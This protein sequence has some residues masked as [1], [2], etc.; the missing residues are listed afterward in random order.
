MPTKTF[1]EYNSWGGVP[2]IG[3]Q[4][5]HVWI[6][7]FCKIAS[8]TDNYCMRNCVAK[9]R[10]IVFIWAYTCH[11]R[12]VEKKKVRHVLPRVLISLY[13]ICIC[14]VAGFHLPDGVPISPISY[15]PCW[16]GTQDLWVLSFC[17]LPHVQ[18][19]LF[20]AE[21]RTSAISFES[22]TSSETLST[23]ISVSIKM[24]QSPSCLHCRSVESKY[25]FQIFY[26]AVPWFVNLVFLSLV[27][28]KW[29]FQTPHDVTVPSV[30]YRTIRHRLA[31]RLRFLEIL[32]INKCPTYT[33]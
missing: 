28:W 31:Q 32:C 12:E 11:N 33:P 15:V 19:R 18:L 24:A 22:L 3:I 7:V 26:R 14:L 4:F 10:H 30:V 20:T 8:T 13:L 23:S 21:L 27:L 6:T 5:R 17:A 16:I 9:V 29:S 25:C 2:T 1:S